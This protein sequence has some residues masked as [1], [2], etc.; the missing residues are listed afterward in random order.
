MLKVISRST[1]DLQSVLDTLVKSAARLC[2]ADIAGIARPDGAVYRQVALYGLP[3]DAKEWTMSHPIEPTRGSVLGRVL[4][5]RPAPYRFQGERIGWRSFGAKY[6]HSPPVVT[7]TKSTR[8]PK[9]CIGHLIAKEL[10]QV[11]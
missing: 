1:F 10:V 5:S 3:P 9:P 2:D 11:L 7:P 4:L 8:S 6:C